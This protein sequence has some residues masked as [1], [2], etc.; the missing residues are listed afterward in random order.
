MEKKVDAVVNSETD[1]LELSF[2]K[3][4]KVLSA[5]AVLA[6]LIY[7]LFPFFNVP[8]GK[9]GLVEW[10][11]SKDISVL[12]SW[13]HTINPFSTKVLYNGGYEV[14]DFNGI[15]VKEKGGWMYDNIVSN[16]DYS[17]MPLAQAITR[18]WHNLSINMS[19]TFRLKDD[20]KSL[21]S[22]YDKSKDKYVSTIVIPSISKAMGDVFGWK[23]FYSVVSSKE[24]LS[25]EIK[26]SISQEFEKNGIELITY[27]F[28][29]IAYS[30]ALEKRVEEIFDSQK[31]RKLAELWKEK[32]EILINTQKIENEAKIEL[33]N[34]IKS[35]WLNVDDYVKLKM[36]KSFEEKWNWNVVPQWLMDLLNG[37]KK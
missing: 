18:D 27:S 24:S 7:F 2:S 10:F 19:V 37:A 1:W 35:K 17:K 36:V 22:I 30:D 32:V 5:V 34:A 9:I 25:D 23:D 16:V 29:K 8:V 33:L 20:E 15:E 13:V 6:L 26:K 11:F 21:I 14:I 28:N 12:K 4:I 3:Y 31:E